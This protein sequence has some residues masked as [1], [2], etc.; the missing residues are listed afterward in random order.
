MPWRAF[1]HLSDDDL[2]AMFA[3]LKTLKPVRNRG[4]DPVLEAA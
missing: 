3:H 4:P 2:R 1:R